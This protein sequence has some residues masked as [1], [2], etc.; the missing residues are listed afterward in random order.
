MSAFLI[1][2]LRI[3]IG[4]LG[5]GLF[6]AACTTDTPAQSVTPTSSI[7]PTDSED[8]PASSF[9]LRGSNNLLER[10][11]RTSDGVFAVDEKQR[12]IF[13][14]IGAEEVLGYGSQEV[15]GRHCF[16]VIQGVDE[17]GRVNCV[18]GCPI[19]DCAR[20]GRLASGQNLQVRTKD[21]SLRWLSVTH[22][23]IDPYNDQPAVMVHVFRDATREV[24]AKTLVGRLAEQLSG[25]M[26]V[27]D[28]GKGDPG[29]E[30]GLTEREMQVLALLARGEGTHA[31]AKELTISKTTARN[32]IQ[33]ILAK[34]GVHTRLE[35]VAFSLR[36]KLVD[37]G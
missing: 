19:M 15:M 34:L 30:C 11:F 26:F 9:Q 12:I 27:Q 37:P 5:L 24:E 33:N 1:H 21:G 18:E 22:T 28:L 14:N 3:L 23:L 13:W 36:H 32:H 29:L 20:Q 2:P 6:V 25:H 31:I 17:S 7:N 16:E 8:A 4:I 35:A 10:I